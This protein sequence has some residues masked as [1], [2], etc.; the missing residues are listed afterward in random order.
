MPIADRVV[1]VTGA[2]GTLGP[3]AVAA[4]ARAGARVGLVGTDPGRL[5]AVAAGAALAD[6]QWVAATADLRDPAAT[7]LAV[8]EVRTALGPVEIVLHLVGGWIGGTRILDLDPADVR[9]MLDQHLWTTLNVARATAPGMVERGWGR[10][11][12]ISA[13]AAAEGAVGQAAYAIAKAAE[14]SLLRTLGRELAGAGVTTNVLVARTIAEPPAEAPAPGAKKATWA[15]PEEVVAAMLYLCSDEAGVVN[16]A[17]IAL[18]G[19]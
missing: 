5:D 11:V 8:D 15:T 17:R 16:G 2:T 1:L 12:A 7:A 3:V 6:G 18:T 9:S 4:F 14:E 10:F 19:R 13:P